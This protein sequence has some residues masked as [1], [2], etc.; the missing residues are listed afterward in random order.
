MITDDEDFLQEKARDDYAL[1][2]F[3]AAMRDKLV[4]AW[5]SGRYGWWD[6]EVCTI[7]DLNLMFF[8]Q[9]AQRDWVSI[10][11]FAMFL[12]QRQY[13]TQKN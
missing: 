3:T 11:N 1:A 9:V 7:N 5:E 12:H 8:E 6:D 13:M 2:Q 10:A 4:E